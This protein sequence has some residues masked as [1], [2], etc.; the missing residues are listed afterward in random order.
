MSQYL[1]FSTK[2][3]WRIKT[4]GLYLPQVLPFGH[5]LWIYFISTNMP[6]T[7]FPVKSGIACHEGTWESGGIEPLILNLGTRHRWAVSF[8]PRPLYLKGNISWYPLFRRLGRSQTW[9]GNF[10][11]EDKILAL[12]GIKP[13]FPDY[14]ACSLLTILTELIQLCSVYYKFFFNK[15]WRL[16][17]DTG[18]TFNLLCTLPQMQYQ[19]VSKH[20]PRRLISTLT[21]W[22]NITPPDR[23]KCFHLTSRHR[24]SCIL[25]QAFH[26]SPENAFYIFNQQIYFIIWYLLDRASLI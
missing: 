24:A 21:L 15:I 4:S 25:G 26:Y 7:C 10:G 1:Q 14:P 20:V 16:I 13:P 18:H 2:N 11:E 5:K 6:W 12:L 22:S 3:V 9:S 23:T 19:A 8:I 17:P